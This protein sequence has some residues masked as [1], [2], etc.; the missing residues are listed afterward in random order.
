VA[1]LEGRYLL[2]YDGVEIKDNDQRPF[3]LAGYDVFDGNGKLKTVFSSNFNGEVS[4]NETPLWD[5]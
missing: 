5:V 1:T 4:R 2:A 3:A